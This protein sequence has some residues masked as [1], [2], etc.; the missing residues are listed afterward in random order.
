M[1]VD[2][3]KD[4]I[5]WHLDWEDLVVFLHAV[6]DIYGIWQIYLLGFIR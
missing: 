4:G 2:G 5:E 3:W 1:G 6:L